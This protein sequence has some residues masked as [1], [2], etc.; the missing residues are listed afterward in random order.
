MTINKAKTLNH[1]QF[2][3]LIRTVTKRQDSLRCLTILALSF[4][5]GLRASEIANI[6]WKDVTDSEGNIL[7]IG[8]CVSLPSNITKGSVDGKV[9]MH[10]M[11]YGCLSALRKRGLHQINKRIILGY[12]NRAMTANA[13]TV[14]MYRLFLD[15]GFSGCSSHSGRRSFITNLA[16]VCNEKRCSLVDVQI[17]ARHRNLKTTS[18]Y[19][20]LS[21]RLTDLARAI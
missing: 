21:E 6:E 8:S 3:S 9:V 4:K 11:L 17:L 18:L 10:K 7:P 19:I 20:D 15:A 16:R 12:R 5:C 13:L 14:F 1:E 2:R